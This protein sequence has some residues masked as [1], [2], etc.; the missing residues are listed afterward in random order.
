[1]KA[2]I[3]RFL[4]GFSAFV[5]PTIALIAN[6]LLTGLMIALALIVPATRVPRDWRIGAPFFLIFGL[7]VFWALLSVLWS[8]DPAHTLWRTLRLSVIFVLGTV[9]C[10]AAY[11]MT[12]PEKRT[13]IACLSAGLLAASILSMLDGLWA[14]YA[15]GSFQFPFS[16]RH[17]LLPFHLPA[18]CFH[19]LILFP[20]VTDALNRRR[21][22]WAGLLTITTASSIFLMGSRTAAV[23]FVAGGIVFLLVRFGRL[24]LPQILLI[25]L[26]LV[27]VSTPTL[28]QI[29]DPGQR[30]V[31]QKAILPISLIHRFI[32][33][34]FADARIAEQPVLGWGLHSSRL[35]PGGE[36]DAKDE[37][38][39]SDLLARADFIPD[40]N[41][42]LLPLHPHNASYQLRLELGLP[43]LILYA[44]L[45]FLAM[46]AVMRAYENTNMQ[47]G[48]VASIVVAFTIGQASFSAWQSWW[49]AAQFWVVVMLVAT[50]TLYR[51]AEDPKRRKPVKRE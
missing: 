49:I 33:W 31:E 42:Q 24:H 29:I 44:A 10:L 3:F 23:A 28:I 48:A 51:D 18:S 43:G 2:T 30:I 38:R 47:R 6:T 12:E 40:D 22:A 25:A 37:P 1:M 15:A 26:P 20:V 21:Y 19:A 34:R 17:L 36:A 50:P 7:L 14:S 9:A 45:Y 41:V 8:V 16:A 5:I 11:H 35:I 27:F 39:Y 32:I 13:T 46:R 4:F